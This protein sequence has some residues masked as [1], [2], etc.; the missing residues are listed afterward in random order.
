MG[1]TCAGWLPAAAL[2]L[3]CVLVSSSGWAQ[4][5]TIKGA[6]QCNGMTV[7]S[8][9]AEDHNYMVIFAVDGSPDVQALVKKV[10]DAFYPDKGLDADTAVKLQDAYIAQLKFCIA[11]DSPAK[12]AG[13]KTGASHYCSAAT[14]SAVTGT[15]Y[16][17]DGKNWIRATRIENT[18]I[19]YPA[20]MLAPDRPFVIPN[21]KPLMLPIAKG[22]TLRCLYVPPGKAMLGAPLFMATRYQEEYPHLVTLTKGFYLGE[23][24]ITQDMWQA[25]AGANPS[26]QKGA[27]IPVEDPLFPDMDKFCE[28]LSQRTGK[29]VRLPSTAEWEYAARSGTSNPGFAEKY[30]DQ[31]SSGARNEVKPV[32]ATKPNAWGFYQMFSCWWE[33]TGDTAM[34]P[35]RAAAVDPHYPAG[36]D[37]ANRAG[38]G[39]VRENWSIAMREFDDEKGLGYAANKFRILVE[40]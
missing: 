28:I 34:Y 14:G 31:Y 21:K 13:Q 11:P 4:E 6:M 5:I 20:R 27:D 18:R 3:I 33:I 37:H 25:V 26:L 32:R 10:L 38:M 23:I 30:A 16:K 2:V 40:E 29:K 22:L 35:Q 1:R 24:P 8:P 9:T 7:P 36:H 15:V 17:K 12:P 39:V 19:N